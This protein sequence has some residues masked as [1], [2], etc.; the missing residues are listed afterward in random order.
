MNI[1]IVLENIGPSETAKDT[2]DIH[3]E[4]NIIVGEED[5]LLP[6][7]LNVEQLMS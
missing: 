3:F 2:K 7:S 5:M 1:I 4:R 6:G